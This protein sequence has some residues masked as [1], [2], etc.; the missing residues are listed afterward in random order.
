[1]IDA[2]L[3]NEILSLRDKFTQILD[4]GEASGELRTKIARAEANLHKIARLVDHKLTANRDSQG[5]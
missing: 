1:M 3:Y 5:T 2:E 4:N